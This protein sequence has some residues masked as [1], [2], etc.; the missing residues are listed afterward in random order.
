MEGIIYFWFM[1]LAWIYITFIMEKNRY[2]D[3]MSIFILI[4]IFSS[5]GEMILGEYHLSLPFLLFLI[6]GYYLSVK[7]G[8]NNMIHYYLSSTTITFAY[9]GTMLFSIYDPVWF[10]IDYRLI[11]SFVVSIVA[12]FLGKSIA[13]KYALFFMSI[14]H[15]ELLY[16]LVM[17]K[18]HN[19]ISIGNPVFLDIVVIGCFSIC[20]WTMFQKLIIF[21]EQN[22]QKLQ[23]LQKSAKEKQG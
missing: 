1:W 16:W 20:I 14:C 8:N 18:F 17:S 5:S 19:S 11:L 6:L 22:V 3:K 4:T 12:I 23:R 13:Q 9:A 2:R 7:Q 15:G 10:V 21:F